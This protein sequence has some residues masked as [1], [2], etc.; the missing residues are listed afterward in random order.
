VGRLG[1]E[2]KEGAATVQGFEGSRCQRFA[3]PGNVANE[4]RERLVMGVVVELV[5]CFP[6]PEVGGCGQPR[7]RGCPERIVEVN[8]T[9]V[10]LHVRA[11][12][13]AIVGEAEFPED[14]GFEGALLQEETGPVKDS[15]GGVLPERPPG[16][17]EVPVQVSD[18][19]VRVVPVPGGGPPATRGSEV[20]V[21]VDLGKEAAQGGMESLGG[22]LR[23]HLVEELPGKDVRGIA[24]TGDGVAEQILGIP[25]GDLVGGRV[26]FAQVETVMIA[27]EE[28]ELEADVPE[29][30]GLQ[31]AI[32]QFGLAGVVETAGRPVGIGVRQ[33]FDSAL[34]RSEREVAEEGPTGAV[35]AEIDS[36]EPPLIRRGLEPVVDG[37]P[38]IALSRL[39]GRR[40]GCSAESDFEARGVSGEDLCGEAVPGVG[41][42]RDGAGRCDGPF[43]GLRGTEFEAE[44]RGMV[45]FVT[46]KGYEWRPP[47]PRPPPDAPAGLEGERPV[48]STGPDPGKIGAVAGHAFKD[49]PKASQVRV[50]SRTDKRDVVA[51]GEEWRAVIEGEE[52]GI[53]GGDADEPA[54]RGLGDV[55]VQGGGE[56]V[57]LAG[58]EDGLRR[59]G[60]R[61][62]GGE[63]R[64]PSGTPDRV[65]PIRRS[66]VVHL[67]AIFV[68]LT[69]E[70]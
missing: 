35:E 29:F 64:F 22:C 2:P 1:A 8:A 61:C 40:D 28:T 45:A 69:V 16:G 37:Q 47:I 43:G 68:R 30:S 65:E 26:G 32:K 11:E 18:V 10:A 5:D 31:N 41:L 42:E 12:S 33:Q 48:L 44:Q 38:G 50:L 70:C 23:I 7:E 27:G 6:P 56:E 39:E 4:G 66:P 17:A 52:S 53:E 25:D 34:G 67:A 51:D 55:E 24:P 9:G 46:G 54:G 13:V 59:V 14:G 60:S 3:V 49:L 15:G 58:D 63:A 19:E 36:R 21:R 20:L 57:V 62:G